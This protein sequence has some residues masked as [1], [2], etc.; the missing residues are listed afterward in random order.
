M[1]MATEPLKI[2]LTGFISVWF[3]QVTRQAC[4]LLF[5]MSNVT[6]LLFAC[7]GYKY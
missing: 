7:F 1:Q 5:T 6:V 4:L 3:E 2:T